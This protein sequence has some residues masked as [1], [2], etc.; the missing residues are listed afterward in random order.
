MKKKRLRFQYMFLSFIC[1]DK[2]SESSDFLSNDCHLFAN[3]VNATATKKWREI[4]VGKSKK[5]K[6]NKNIVKGERRKRD[7]GTSWER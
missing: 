2:N 5:R 1:Q 4:D 6:E 7:Q 3:W